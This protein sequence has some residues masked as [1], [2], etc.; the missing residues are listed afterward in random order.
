[1]WQDTALTV[2]LHF[3]SLKSPKTYEDVSQESIK[4]GI[5]T[6]NQDL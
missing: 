2:Y 3:F 6:S 5:F 1:M 4:K